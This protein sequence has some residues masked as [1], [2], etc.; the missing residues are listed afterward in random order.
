MKKIQSNI[1]IQQPIET[2]FAFVSNFEN[3]TKWWLNVTESRIISELKQGVGT[4]Y[5][6]TAQFMGKHFNSVLAITAYEPPKQVTLESVESAIPFVALFTFEPVQ[7]GTRITMTA[8]ADGTGFYKLVQ[9][10]FNF[11]LQRTTDKFFLKLKDL[12]ENSAVLG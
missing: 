5:R 7:Q 2:V 1:I 6:Q 4:T 11:L 8:T 10:L 12:L 9:P 3:D